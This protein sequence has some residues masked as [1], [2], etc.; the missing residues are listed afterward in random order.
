MLPLAERA[1]GKGRLLAFS[2]LPLAGKERLLRRQLRAPPH[3]ILAKGHWP[4]A[5][6]ARLRL[7]LAA[8]GP[9]QQQLL[10]AGKGRLL[11]AAKARLLAAAGP[12]WPLPTAA[13]GRLQRLLAAAKGWLLS[14]AGPDWPLPTAGKEGPGLSLPAAEKAWLLGEE[15]PLL[16]LLLRTPPLA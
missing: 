1:A 7:L 8:A 11:A 13:R 14:A 2:P 15:R 4:A 12:D 10:A 16:L 3:R 9:Q 5:E 6:K